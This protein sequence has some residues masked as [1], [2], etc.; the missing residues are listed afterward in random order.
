MVGSHNAES[1]AQGSPSDIVSK[2]GP[3]VS[4]S[5]F[6][7]IGAALHAVAEPGIPVHL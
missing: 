1:F 2:P 5:P 4:S 3:W 6:A 7:E